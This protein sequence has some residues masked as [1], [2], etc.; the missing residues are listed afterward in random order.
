MFTNYAFWRHLFL[1]ALSGTVL[2]LK[3]FFFIYYFW[4]CLVFIAVRGL[5]LAAMNRLLI[6]M[7]PLVAEHGL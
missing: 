3:K 1:K 7:V 6:A 2:A 5:S 4:L